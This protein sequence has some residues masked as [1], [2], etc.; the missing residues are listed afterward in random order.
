MKFIKSVLPW[1][2]VVA[3]SFPALPKEPSEKSQVKPNETQLV[4][5]GSYVN[6]AGNVVHSPAHTKDGAIPSGAKAKCYDGTYSFSQ[7][8][9]GTCSHHGGVMRWL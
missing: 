8:R 4:E 6:K 5:H 9:R 7:S 3:L 2:F 1:L